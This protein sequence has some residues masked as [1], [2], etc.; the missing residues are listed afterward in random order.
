MAGTEEEGREIK[1]YTIKQQRGMGWKKP[2]DGRR[3]KRKHRLT[4]GERWRGEKDK[5]APLQAV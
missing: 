3:E 4:N 1:E 5:C 2:R